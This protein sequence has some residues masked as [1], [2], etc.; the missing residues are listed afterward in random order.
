MRRKYSNSFHKINNPAQNISN[1]NIHGISWIADTAY[2]AGGEF[3]LF[4]QCM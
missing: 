4:A 2:P 1:I 3:R